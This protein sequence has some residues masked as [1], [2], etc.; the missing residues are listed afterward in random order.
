MAL[1]PHFSNASSTDLGLYK[2]FETNVLLLV[3]QGVSLSLEHQ[4]SPHFSFGN[5]LALF[6]QKFNFENSTFM[7]KDLYM[8]GTKWDYYFFQKGMFGPFAELQLK[9]NYSL[10]HISQ[11]ENHMK[12]KRFFVIPVTNIGY[13]FITTNFITFAAYFGLGYTV[14]SQKTQ[15]GSFQSFSAENTIQEKIKREEKFFHPDYGF[16][17]GFL[18]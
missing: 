8:F 13:R 11:N 6:Q 9:L 14:F 12:I 15:K 17:V 4:W 16:T 2:V 1:I 3:N 10:T 7:I 18:F 5:Q